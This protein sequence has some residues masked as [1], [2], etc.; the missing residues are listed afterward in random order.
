MR[1]L[2][3]RRERGN[4]MILSAFFIILLVMLF[5]FVQDSLRKSNLEQA[6]QKLADDTA[7][8]AASYVP[9][10]SA[11]SYIQSTGELRPWMQ[12][13]NYAVGYHVLSEMDASSV[14]AYAAN[15]AR[16]YVQRNAGNSAAADYFG[17]YLTIN[18]VS[19][20][21]VARQEGDRE[22][23]E[24]FVEVELGTRWASGTMSRDEDLTASAIARAV[25]E[26]RSFYSV[27]TIDI[28]NPTAIPLFVHG[29]Y[30]GG[31]IKINN[32]RGGNQIIINGDMHANT[33]NLD[34]TNNDS[35]SVYG[36]VSAA[37]G[38]DTTG[39]YVAGGGIYPSPD[40]SWSFPA[41]PEV[42]PELYQGT[43]KVVDGD[44]TLSGIFPPAAW[45]SQYTN[46]GTLYI[47]GGSL[48][49]DGS[50]GDPI[51]TGN[52]CFYMDGDLHF[53]GLNATISPG[54]YQTV[55]MVNGKMHLNHLR[56]PAVING[57]VL[58]NGLFHANNVKDADFPFTINGGLYTTGDIH[59]NNIPV[60]FTLND[61]PMPR[62][63]PKP[64]ITYP[65]A[66]SSPPQY[67]SPVVTLIH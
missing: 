6:L 48:S 20:K 33:S 53:N 40:I 5:F 47:R 44:Y 45:G 3:R 63:L 61:E 62:A 65:S 39:V 22:I 64:F 31:S 12:E 66:V 59:L 19:P 10:V 29:M 16:E 38:V 24:Y 56:G 14:D 46:G 67:S 52:W 23:I 57:A 54:N 8:H 37:S 13:Q 26:H 7:L 15:A 28:K 50:A 42:S 9:S 21:F 60:G 30:A 51:I 18:R 27:G 36:T 11:A 58:C 1:C 55:F 35:A 49:V 32:V 41:N 2:N 17:G 43:V 25:I 34:F 4:F